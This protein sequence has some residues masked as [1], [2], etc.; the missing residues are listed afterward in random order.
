MYGFE[1]EK[2]QNCSVKDLTLGGGGPVVFWVVT[3]G[4]VWVSSEMK[5]LF[6]RT[7]FGVLTAALIG[8]LLPLS[9]LATPINC[10]GGVCPPQRLECVRKPDG[11]IECKRV[12]DSVE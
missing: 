1:R 3:I 9:A 4:D 7:A 2:S 5:S 6:D 11:S 12:E 10:P 8:L